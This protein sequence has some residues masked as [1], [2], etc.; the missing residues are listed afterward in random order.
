M[1]QSR[2]SKRRELECP[3]CW[4]AL[5]QEAVEVRGPDVVIDVCPTC[6]GIWLDSGELNR[7]LGDR[8][9]SQYLSKHIGTQSKSQLVCPACGWLMDIET[10]EDVDVDVCLNCG[11]VWLD[12][13]ELEKLRAISKEGFEGDERVKE[14]ERWEELMQRGQE[15]ALTGLLR[16]LARR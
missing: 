2:K 7:L 1:S 12:S 9:L 15:S 11:G 6:G 5:Q 8:K 16:W 4:V 3:R 14:Q 13:D 10:A